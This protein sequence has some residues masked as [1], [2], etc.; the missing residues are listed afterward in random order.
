MPAINGKREKTDKNPSGANISIS[1]IGLIRR[2]A[3]FMNKLL[4]TNCYK[5]IRLVCMSLVQ[6]RAQSKSQPNF[7]DV[8][9]LIEEN[10]KV[11]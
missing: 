3:K 1:D 10:T 7:L 6:P 4:T 11:G 8:S 2:Y 9:D 5:L